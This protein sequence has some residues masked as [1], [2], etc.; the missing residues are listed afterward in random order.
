MKQQFIFLLLV[1]FT[2]VQCKNE[3]PFVSKDIIDAMEDKQNPKIGNIAV[4]CNND[5]FYIKKITDIP[6]QLTT[7]SSIEKKDIK[8]SHNGEKIAYLDSSGTPVIIDNMGKILNTL[9]QFKNVKCMDWSANDETLYMLINRKVDFFGPALTIPAITYSGV[10]SNVTPILNFITISSNNDIAYSYETSTFDG[11]FHTVI[12]KKNDNSNNEQRLAYVRDMLVKHLLF[13]N[14]TDEL[15]VGYDWYDSRII[16]K[17]EVYPYLS[18]YPSTILESSEQYMDPIYRTDL[19]YLVGGY[20]DANSNIFKIAATRFLMSEK[21]N[22]YFN[23]L[24]TQNYSRL[25]VNWK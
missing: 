7:S 23:N 8:I 12:F 11:T 10:A 13:V 22:Y 14:I 3:S 2:S 1:V 6:K 9:V 19:Q 5:I 4:I 16:S 17:I 15:M 24:S 25:Y 21:G 18:V 20:K